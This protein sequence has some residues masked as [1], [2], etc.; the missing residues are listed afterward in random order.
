MAAGVFATVMSAVRTSRGVPSM[1][2]NSLNKYPAMN[3]TLF[4]PNLL[5]LLTFLFWSV[6]SFYPLSQLD[7][8]NESTQIIV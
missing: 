7:L 8:S 5:H 2:C 6:S 3:S 4:T 1:F